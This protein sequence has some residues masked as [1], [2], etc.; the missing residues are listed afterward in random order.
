MGRVLSEQE[1]HNLAMNL[2]GRELEQSGFEF[3]AV[4]SKFGKTPQF[5]CL[6]EKQLHFIVVR[7]ALYPK[8]ASIFDPNLMQKMAIHAGKFEARAYY[9]GVDFANASNA[10]DPIFL[11]EPYE[12]E[13]NGLI[14]I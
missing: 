8:D 6:R 3:L 14:E 2:V 9:A 11:N 13:Y 5:V 7:Y 1:L 10:N 4:N 12:V